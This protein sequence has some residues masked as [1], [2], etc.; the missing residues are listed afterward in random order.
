MTSGVLVRGSVRRR[1]PFQLE[2]YRAP[3]DAWGLFAPH[4]YLDRTLH[5]SAIPYVALHDGR[6]VAFCATLSSFGH[7]GKY[8][9]HRIV[10]LPDFQ[11]IG[12][13]ST[14][15]NAVC[16]MVTDERFESRQKKTGELLGRG[17][18]RI[19]ITSSSP[20]VEA[21]CRGPP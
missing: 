5:H 16:K 4:H 13:G 10:T 21:M 7:P 15:L 8:T 1:P 6:P 14:L 11:G 12:V 19:S 17:H 20:V 9:I 2:G 18:K 3:R